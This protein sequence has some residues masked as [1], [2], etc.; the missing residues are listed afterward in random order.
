MKK[1]YAILL[2]SVLT[3]LAILTVSTVMAQAPLNE[4]LV[5]VNFRYN[6]QAGITSNMTE[7][8]ELP[9]D[10]SYGRFIVASSSLGKYSRVIFTSLKDGETQ[11]LT[12]K[13]LAEWGNASAYF[14]G[15]EFTIQV[16]KDSRD[17]GKIFVNI[18]QV[19][20]GFAPNQA[21][22]SQCGST[23]NRTPFIDDAIG[24]IVPIGC[25]GWLITNG[26]MVTAG[27]CATSSAQILEFNV[28]PSNSNG[29]INHPPVADQF[30]IV[31]SS[32]QAG[33]SHDWGVYDLNQN[34]L[35]Q[36]ALARQ[37]KSFN[38]VQGAT[39]G[40]VNTIRITGYGVERSFNNPYNPERNQVSQTHTG[41]LNSA[42]GTKIYYNADTEGGNSGSPVIDE[43]T[44]NAIGVHTHGG[45]SS[46]GGN[47]SGTPATLAEFWN[48]MGL[49]TPP[50]TGC[51]SSISSFPYTESFES[52]TGAWSQ[53]TGDNLNWTRDSGGTPSSNTGPSSGSAG[54]FYMYVETSGNGTG[55]PNKT[56]YFNSPCFDLSGTSTATFAFDYHMYG[57]AMG[58]LRLQA[59]T[60]NGSSWSTIWTQS[61][62]QG[63]SWQS[64][65]VN[66]GSYT[67]GDVQLRFFATSGSS[68][69]SDIAVDNINVSTSGSGGGGS[70]ST[71][72][73]TLVTDRYASETSWTLRNSAGAT[74]AS[75][76]GSYANSTTYTE[77]F[78]L[79]AGC[80]DFTIN[81]SYGDGIC[82]AYGSGSYTLREGSTTLASGGSFGSS[83]T[84]NFCVT[85]ESANLE[86]VNLGSFELVAFPSPAST[87]VS[88]KSNDASNA[89]YVVLD[90]TGRQVAHGQLVN[91]TASVALSGLK[92]GLYI[93]RATEGDK[94]A[95]VKFIKE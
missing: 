22:Q 61:G 76:G 10:A 57:S 38:V 71:V 14:N 88:I 46:S 47:N 30:P 33:S 52:G 49:G 24:R 92:T 70:N 74:V 29:S 85:N 36:T 59:S 77:T 68:W 95:T 78:S 4:S 18:D 75:G 94:V 13:Q 19:I 62:N 55:Y 28:P 37:G 17:E 63:N 34:S 11:E 35:G 31:Q 8:I 32:R 41:S 72:V 73:L 5:N 58:T 81:D 9:K 7:K 91:G 83:E 48:A 20:A 12:A 45:C 2:K 66:L 39:T 42:N 21:N 86:G 51:S 82:C 90:V 79:P 43:A 27:H 23:D 6:Y 93:V 89:Q 56:A 25:T 44:G 53:G 15:N 40:N 60:N 64:A 67:G 65:S 50:P 16:I 54:S 69:S 84:K 80:Y 1:L 87:Q 3:A 26:K